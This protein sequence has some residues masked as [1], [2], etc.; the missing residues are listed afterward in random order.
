M[1]YVNEIE[2][3][4]KPRLDIITLDK[5]TNQYDA[6]EIFRSIWDN[7]IEY[8]ERFYVIYLNR[9]NKVL[10]YYL[11]SVGS[12]CGTVVETKMIFQ[13][14]INLHASSIIIAHNHPSGNLNPSEAD[15]KLT[16]KICEAG[17]ILEIPVQDHIILTVDSFYSFGQHNIL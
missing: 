11:I 14:A 9:Q 12:S 17:S 13:P 6:V 8:R 2:V 1:N 3:L 15:I 7:D 4:F 5:V 10:G 16:K